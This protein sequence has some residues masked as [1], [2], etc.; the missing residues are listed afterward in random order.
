MRRTAVGADETPYG[1]IRLPGPQPGVKYARFYLA[2]HEQQAQSTTS[3]L[4]DNYA[5]ETLH[6]CRLL[7]RGIRF[8]L[9]RIA[10]RCEV[11]AHFH[12][13]STLCLTDGHPQ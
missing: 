11:P 3:D 8:T 12:H 1:D 6:E 5:R 4:S 7:T 2:G 13:A 10:Q 9:G